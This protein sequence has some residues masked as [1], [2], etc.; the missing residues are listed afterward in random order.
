MEALLRYLPWDEERS[1]GVYN[2]ARHLVETVR[3]QKRP[4]GELESFL[5]SFSLNTEEGIALMCLAEALLRIPDKATANEFIKDKITSANWNQTKKNADWVVKSAGFGLVV[6]R[7]TLESALERIGAPFIREAMNQAMRIMGSKFILG[8]TIQKAMENAVPYEKKGYRISYDMLGEGAR[9]A[10]DAERYFENYRMAINAMGKNIKDGDQKLPGLSVKLSA[11]HPRYEYAQKDYCLPAMQERLIELCRLASAQDID[12]TIDAEEARRLEISLALIENVMK[13][14]D[15]HE[16]EGLGLAIQAYQKRCMPLIDHLVDR[17]KNYGRRLQVR[18]V[19]GAYWDSEIKRAQVQGLEDYPVFTRKV[20]T[21]LSY[22]TCAYKLLKNSKNFKPLFGTHNAHTMAAIISMAKSAKADFEFQRLHSM[23]EELHDLVM[24]EY[25]I[26]GIIYAPVGKHADLLAY[27]VRR[28]LENGANS[29]FLNKIA[30]PEIPID[31]VISDP[32]TAAQQNRLKRH[33]KISYPVN[34]Y[35]D[36]KPFGRLNSAG[37]DLTDAETTEK[38]QRTVSDYKLRPMKP[39]SLPQFKK[40][41]WNEKPERRAQILD[42]IADLF[43]ENRTEL[44]TICVKEGK[45]TIPDAL[46]EVR[47]A[48]DFCRY[49]ANHGRNDFS[50]NGIALPGVTGES[51]HFMLQARGPFVC[52]SPWNFPLAI[53]TGQVVA[54]LMAGNAVIAK[55]AEQTPRIA[56]RAVELMHKAG[57]PKDILQ[58]AIGDGKVGAALVGQKEVAGVAFTGSTDVARA[59]NRT[60]ADKDGPIARLIAETGGMNAM[61]VDST[62]LPEQVIDD[63]VLSAFGSAGQRCSA[64]RILCL[65]EEIAEKILHMLKGAIE[66]IKVGNPELVSTDIGPVIDE[67]ALNMLQDHKQRLKAFARL[68]AEAPL[69]N[70]LEDTYF[71]PCAYEIEDISWLEQEIFGPVLHVVRFKRKNLKSLIQSINQTGYGLTFGVHSRLESF[72]H[73][74]AAAIQTGNI[75]INRSMIGAVVG[76]QPFGGQGL[77]GT[78]PKAGGPYYLHGFATEKVVSIDTTAAGGNASLVSIGE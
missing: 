72:Q 23:A 16:W 7:G 26:P 65:Q 41:V 67:N 64:L 60:L 77:S 9:T 57:V 25:N 78:G 62:A 1:A 14:K 28:L 32:V 18:L 53:F 39:V 36:E 37:M 20:N 24:Q 15:L 38:I 43:E 71:A 75:Y 55:P 54:A 48:V 35:K 33:P 70:N 42:K 52:I 5:Q 21:D 31:H 68:I 8:E 73:E 59:I 17:S 61:I 3:T 34:L 22:L 10:E 27:L 30:N 46:A 49:Y 40:H 45:K 76:S 74:A 66:E 47:E 63:V 13:Q 51:N 29:S 12:L 4:P 2:I 6:T 50:A 56:I 11:L 69:D 58:I 44:M 19:K